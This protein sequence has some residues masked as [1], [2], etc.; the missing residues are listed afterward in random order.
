MQRKKH[1]YNEQQ[2]LWSGVYMPVK[3]L[4]ISMHRLQVTVEVPPTVRKNF[5]LAVDL[6]RL[7]RGKWRSE[8]VSYYAEENVRDKT[9]RGLACNIVVFSTADW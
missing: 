3:K 7:A 5:P 8:W 4:F 9:K 2:K 6:N 1:T